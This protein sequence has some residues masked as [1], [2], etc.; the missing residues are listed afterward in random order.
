M[1]FER[2]ASCQDPRESTALLPVSQARA[3]LQQRLD[4]VEGNEKLP[5]ERALGRV[6]AV[7]VISP[8]DVPNHTNAAMDGFALAASA[9]PSAGETVWL[10]VVGEAWAG[11]PWSGSLNGAEA[12]KIATGAV[13]PTG[14]DTVVIVEHTQS[15]GQRVLIG[16]DTQPGRNVR[17][18]GEDLR[19]GEVV[20][21]S[22][23]SLS[24]AEIG[25]LALLGLAQICVKRKLKVAVF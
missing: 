9:L 6:L 3:L 7:D 5:I 2:Q 22:G 4:V 13:M 17:H 8:I 10:D 23:T 20:F 14:A 16:D 21:R 19:R 25:Q 11:R 1:D 12:V 15:D 24:A 18:A